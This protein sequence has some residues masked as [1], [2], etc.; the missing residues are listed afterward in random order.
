MGRRLQWSKQKLFFVYCFD[1]R[2]LDTG[3]LDHQDDPDTKAVKYFEKGHT[4][5]SVDSS[6]QIEK[7]MKMK[8]VYN[9]HDSDSVISRS[10][11]E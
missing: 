8:N 9:F 11:S 4:F 3:S 5:I 2:S 1:T 6:H 10:E 7:G